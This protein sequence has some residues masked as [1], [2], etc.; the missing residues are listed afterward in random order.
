[1]G[2]LSRLLLPL[3]L[4]LL[5]APP[6]E[7]KQTAPPEPI[8]PAPVVQIIPSP[9]ELEPEPEPDGPPACARVIENCTVD[10][11]VFEL[12]DKINSI[13]FRD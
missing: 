3:F 11:T 9:A 12:Y 7:R 6:P 5:L 8:S 4:L 13:Y 10:F 2:K 1:M